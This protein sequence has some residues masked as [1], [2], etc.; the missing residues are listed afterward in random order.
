MCLS[1]MLYL[2]IF[3]CMYLFKISLT[4]PQCQTYTDLAG[5]SGTNCSHQSLVSVPHTLP[6]ETEILLLNFNKI[7]SISLSL[8]ENL[9]KLKD[10]DLS[11]NQIQHFDPDYPLS[12]EKLNL[13]SNSLTR[14]PNFSNLRR[15]RKLI[16]D[17][18]KISA[19]P[20]GAFDDL[21]LLN[22]L[23]I[24]GNTVRV[25]PEHIFDPLE[26]LRYLTL[27][28]NKI[29]K[30][31]SNLLQNLEEL[32][33]FDVSNNNLKTIPQDIAGIILAYI[34]LYNNPWHC[35]C[36]TVEYLREWIELN[37]GNIYNSSV[38]PDSESV[39]CLT[40]SVWEGTPII[41]FPIEQNC[42]SVTTLEMI[43][44]THT[45]TER[46]QMVTLSNYLL[47]TSPS[48]EI[49]APYTD[50]AGRN[51]A[52]CSHQSLVSV[53][54][55]LPLQTEI[56]LLNFNNITSISLSSFE[57]LSKLKDLDLSNNQ[58]QHFD[59]DYP[60]SIEKLNLSSNS[61]TRVPNFSN[62]RSLRKL[63]LDHNKISALPR[64]AFDDLV[65]LN[66]LSIRG[67]TVQV[68]P[69]H[70]FDPLE[71][72]RY[73]TLSANKIE[74]FPSNLLQNLEELDT[75]DVSNNNLKTI[76][77]D[78][79]G[80]ILAYIYLYNNPWH[81][82]CETVE[83]L[84]E[85]IELN[86]GNIYNSSVE[87]DSESVVCL[88]PSV[89]EGTPI[90]H[91]PIEQNCHS[92]TTLEMIP[93]THTVTERYQMVT[94][95]NYL[96]QI[97]PSLE[98]CAPYT[99]LAGRIGANCSHQS[100]VSVPH[101]LPLQTEILL[102]NFNNI[103]SISLS[104]FENLSKLKD[105]DLSHNQIQHFDPDY[106]LSI[107]K[108]NLS[109]N[110]L[111]RVPNFNLRRLRKLILDH[112]K[113]SAL[114]RGAFDDLVLLN[115]LS[116]R[117]NTV[118][119]LPEHIFDPLEDLR[120][121][122]LSANKIE[123]FPS[124]LLQNV[125]Q[126]DTFDVSNN[127]ITT[128][129]QDFVN[130]VVPYIY[131]YNNPWHCDCETVEY[132]REWIEL[133]EGNIYNSSVE[134]DSESV[135]CLTPS[136]W[137][138]TPV[139][140]FPIEQNCHSVTTPEII[141][142]THTVT[143]RYQMVTLSSYLL[144]TSPSLEIC[145]PY[146]DLAGRNG[147][148][149]S[150]QSLVSVPHS[151]PL[152]TEILLLNFNNITSISLSSFGNLS[153]LKDLDLS[154]NQIQHFDP[155]YSLS[156]E[157]LNLSSNCLTR[158]PNFSNLRSLRK[159]ILDHNKISAL[160]RGAFDDLVLL[161]ELSIRGNTV[162][163]LPE[164]IFDPLENLRYL[165]LSANKIKS[166][167]NNSLNNLKNLTA[168]DVSKNELRTVPQDFFVRNPV[169][170]IH[171]YDN[172]WHC[173]CDIQYLSEW[174]KLNEDKLYR[175]EGI[176]NDTAILCS[177][178]SKVRGESLTQ[179]PLTELC[180]ASTPDYVTLT[181]LSSSNVQTTTDT[182]LL[183]PTSPEGAISLWERRFG[184]LEVLS[185]LGSSCLL[186]F[187]L[188]CLSL[189]LLLV[190]ICL[191]LFYILRFHRRYYAPLKNLGKRRFNIR[192]VRYSL[193]VPDLRQIYPALSPGLKLGGIEET[194]STE[195]LADVLKSPSEGRG[196]LADGMET[197]ADAFGSFL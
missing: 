177:G 28:A 16:L 170:C 102:L 2:K 44:Q 40:P 64:G 174:I 147:A 7:T 197:P 107:E 109:S 23:S 129:P 103:T 155:D 27:S 84:R 128:I 19:L 54:H 182:D 50:L 31:P 15:L 183:H 1:R 12:I 181:T 134:P 152:Q 45:V 193:L 37:E 142:Q 33:T 140:H 35:D 83:Y 112:N 144:Q 67:N 160:P 187:I 81:C 39:V 178:P 145:A 14:V 108:L 57:N 94:L 185:K 47:Q 18:N 63:I 26:D 149:C 186:L 66:E 122:T 99:D 159:L 38:E 163:V 120:Y 46:Y 43:P 29:E 117:G 89:W 76:P 164:H 113:I 32:D 65:L 135:V 3:C 70:I 151:L 153:K 69:E 68:L 150:H 189:F 87:P 104:S 48:L 78:I 95:S 59:P 30:F 191:L 72:L 168:F 71:D 179:I 167:P 165:T 25:L 111:T 56:L 92:V 123:K 158:V 192:L 161:D 137:E 143:E 52:N 11:N 196:P 194:S 184:L 13:S 101:S 96:L 195:A 62:L 141:P 100:L 22:E 98:I 130:D 60:L 169:L 166:L 73:L 106:P 118:R 8:F 124:N 116:I 176:P 61:L 55:S 136:V 138:G 79:A 10:L 58:I 74:K 49:C 131:L 188:H 21:V 105:V 110:S 180:K 80:I 132:L 90:I 115:E 126:L 119:V 125:K 157:K 93:Q 4:V 75:F 173:N 133:N 9:S 114:P 121:L 162:R 36:E 53:P 190:E 24:R 86:E 42:H 41:H 88:T 17:H 97:S 139:T 172:P 171:L 175:G 5:K 148:N 34:Y 20:R 77:Q 127:N 82:D 6:L 154:N 85:W 51:G 146:T 156:I 91:F